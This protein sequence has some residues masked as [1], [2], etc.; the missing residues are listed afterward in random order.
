MSR[1]ML[2][3]DLIRE[4]A[5]LCQREMT[6]ETFQG[7]SYNVDQ[8]PGSKNTILWEPFSMFQRLESE[9]VS[10]LSRERENHGFSLD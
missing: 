8:I 7:V 5:G 6:I 3:H 10:D 2:S 9:R 4:P 1:C